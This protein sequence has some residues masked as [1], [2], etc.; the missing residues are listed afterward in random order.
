MK[1]ALLV[2]DDDTQVVKQLKW[3][4]HDHFDVLHA[5]GR[6]DIT[7]EITRYRPGMALVDL[8]MPPTLDTPETGLDV[9][10]MLRQYHPEVVVIG[11]SVDPDAGLDALVRQAGAV[12]FIRKPFGDADIRR[13]LADYEARW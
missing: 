9:I 13:I 1:P 6:A 2:V 3:A 7:A 8:H 10:R 11:I 4:L 5:L 12:R